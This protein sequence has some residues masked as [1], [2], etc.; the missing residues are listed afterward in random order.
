MPQFSWPSVAA[1]TRRGPIGSRSERS[2]QGRGSSRPGPVR[3]H[4]GRS[5]GS[6][7]WAYLGGRSSDCP[8][9]TELAGPELSAWH[10]NVPSQHGSSRR[11]L[12]YALEACPP[13]AHPFLAK[14][15]ERRDG[16]LAI[17][18]DIQR[19]AK[20]FYH[21]AGSKAVPD[22]RGWQVAIAALVA[23]LEP[24]KGGVRR[25]PGAKEFCRAVLRVSGP[26]ESLEEQES[27]PEL[28]P[29]GSPHEP[30]ASQHGVLTRHGS[31]LTRDR[32]ESALGHGPD[33]LHSEVDPHGP[34]DSLKRGGE[35]GRGQECCAPGT[36]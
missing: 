8:Q 17:P 19:R 14:D 6:G 9:D 1:R 23:L 34:S 4:R 24:P 20:A 7:L 28:E 31:L 29:G 22:R 35:S 21:L 25:N 16:G 2:S 30:A 11:D 33:D 12:E 5:H 32:F 15:V 27:A 18:E 3:F 10:R 36:P 26:E 13:V